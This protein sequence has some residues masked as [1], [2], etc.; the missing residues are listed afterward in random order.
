[1]E[2]VSYNRSLWVQ[3]KMGNFKGVPL[4]ASPL[5]SS[6]LLSPPPFFPPPFRSPPFSA[7]LF[8]LA[9]LTFKSTASHWWKSWRVLKGCRVR[10]LKSGA[11]FAVC[12]FCVS[13]LL[14]LKHWILSDHFPPSCQSLP[15]VCSIK[16]LGQKPWSS[17]K[18]GS[19]QPGLQCRPR[20][21]A[22]AL[23]QPLV[24]SR[25][26]PGPSVLLSVLWPCP[27]NLC[28]LTLLRFSPWSQMS[29]VLIRS[30]FTRSAILYWTSHMVSWLHFLNYLNPT[31]S[32][33]YVSST[34]FCQNPPSSGLTAL[35]PPTS[36]LMLGK[37][38]P[39]FGLES[40]PSSKTVLHKLW[41][42]WPLWPEQI[43]GHL[44]CSVFFSIQYG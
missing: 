16:L 30:F 22:A 39:L 11:S 24:S 34:N 10:P 32:P 41:L 7:L 18:V 20:P 33:S 38:R 1:M 43:N 9:L 12:V 37:A 31:H 8:S 27:G 5:L 14:F 28:L 19:F 25:P 2:R 40:E 6:P 36:L 17:D 44:W 15:I 42:L 3:M 23:P 4:L 35:G 26:S 13:L 21:G 29:S